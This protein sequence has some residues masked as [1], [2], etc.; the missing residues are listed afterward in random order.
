MVGVMTSVGAVHPIVE[1]PPQ[2]IQTE[3]LVALVETFE[4]DL[5]LVRHPVVIRIAQIKELGGCRNK[6]SIAPSEN[7]R[8]EIQVV[9]KE[10][11]LF[12]VSVS[13]AI[14]QYPDTSTGF[15][16]AIHA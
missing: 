4:Q 15:A 12:V 16:A 10:M 1:S 7:A 5:T 13:I 3:L 9:R 11:T 8:W 14:F 6:D 2:V